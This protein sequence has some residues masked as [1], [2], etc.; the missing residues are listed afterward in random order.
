MNCFLWRHK[1][2]QTVFVHTF[3]VGLDLISVVKAYF[4]SE[5]IVVN[6]SRPSDFPWNF[7][8]K[9]TDPDGDKIC[10]RIR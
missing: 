3:A 9:R 7:S 10:M 2:L 6:P 1:E 4:A 5:E 8:V